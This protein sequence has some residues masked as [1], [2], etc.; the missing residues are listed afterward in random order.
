MMTSPF[1]PTTLAEA[2]ARGWD[3]LDVVLITG[4]AHVDHPAF[5]ASLLGRLLEAEGYR[6]GLIARP[7]VTD[8]ESVA[9]LGT[10]RL[11]FGITAGAL[12]SLV[13]NRTAEKKPRSDDAYAPGGRA[14]GRPDRALTVYGNLV[15]RRFGKAAVIVAG[16]LEASLRRL[17]HYDYWSDR[18]RRSVLMDCGADVLVHGM[19][20][21][22]ILAIARALD[23]LDKRPRAAL[24]HSNRVG[25]PLAAPVPATKVC[26]MARVDALRDIPGIV[27]RVPASAEAPVDGLELPSAEEVAAD[28]SVHARA[29]RLEERHR[30]RRLHQI[31]GAMRVIVNPPW[32]PMT[33]AELE[34]VYAL[35]FTRDPHPMYG[36][37]RVPALEQVRFSVTSHRGCAGGCAFCAI[38][39]H[40]GKLIQ[41]RREQAVLDEVAAITRHPEFR[42]TVP[43]LGGPTANL[44]GARCTHEAPCDRPS[45]LWP[46]RCRHLDDGQARYV[47]LLARARRVP[48]VKHLFVT[49]GLRMDL[50]LTSE[51]LLDALARHHT[52]GHLKVAPE[53]VCP[54]ALRPM[55][56]PAGDDFSRFLQ[57]F[58]QRSRAAGKS[59]YVV[60]Y[61]IAAHPGTTLDHMIEAAR[62]LRRE[63]LVV[64]QVQLFTPTPGTA[65]TM[66]YATGL[67]PDTGAPVFVERD[68]KRRALQ[69]ALLLA[70]LP[71]QRGKVREALRLAGREELEREIC[72]GQTPRSETSPPTPTLP[73]EGGGGKR[74]GRGS[75]KDERRS[76]PQ[77]STKRSQGGGG[78]RA[79]PSPST[80]EGWGGGDRRA[81]QDADQAGDRTSPTKT[82]QRSRDLRRESTDAE[83]HLWRHLRRRQIAGARFRRQHPLGPY[84]VDFVSLD[85]RLVVE[86]DGGQ[87]ADQRAYDEAR[88]Q[89][90]DGRGF[91]VIRFWNHEV[92]QETE[93]VLQT[94]HDELTQQTAPPHASPPPR[95]GR[96]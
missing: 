48:G 29:F 82:V 77:P 30:G 79:T 41:S 63:R 60:P 53:H 94:I 66:M 92:F 32:P 52:S 61:F 47:A 7:D 12:D 35:P 28:P 37:A 93:A 50:A 96:G 69:K 88:S 38:G 19:G 6:V 4:D 23:A 68:P 9:A 44:Y 26:A 42:G 24:T 27:H 70:H 14:G 90:L 87:H 21:G 22:P 91:R 39:R 75:K 10:P 20:E 57:A 83:R 1:L 65:A 84:I 13:A 54:D 76:H 95:G 33:P 85:H 5:P 36:D 51:P 64:E 78:R 67:D 89:W 16:G 86:L 59:Q 43:D 58:R 40:Q 15:R 81:R 80:G 31:N 55:R 8:P 17:A 72:G 25:A 11:F 74:R 3:E 34:R 46:K 73:L 2:Q 18:V 49:T 56:K 71:A 45:C 62:F